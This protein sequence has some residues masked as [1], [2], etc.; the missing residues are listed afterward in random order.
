MQIIDKKMVEMFGNIN[1]KTYLCGEMCVK[2]C[3]E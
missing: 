3:P 1:N 2:S